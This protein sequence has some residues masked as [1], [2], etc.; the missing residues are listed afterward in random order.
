MKKFINHI[1]ERI[2]A[3]LGGVIVMA[4]VIPY[5]LLGENAVV[6]FHDQLDGEVLGYILRAKYLFTG[7]DSY[8]E[9][10]NGISKNGFFP[11]S[12]LWILFYKVLPPI[13]AYV[14]CHIFCMLT[15]YCGMYIC[16]KRLVENAYIAVFC[17]ILFAY[18]PLFSVYG[19][20]QYGQPL[21]FYA[22]FLLYTGKR[23][24]CALGSIV[25]Y[26]FTSSLVLV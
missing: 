2:P 5:L 17:G 25:L 16:L 19:L 1:D 9:M 23:R 20:C 10:M 13:A 15:A 8:P 7:V 6:N 4:A 21:L 26:A 18:L 12:P 3:V 22:F 14:F 11:P 24:F